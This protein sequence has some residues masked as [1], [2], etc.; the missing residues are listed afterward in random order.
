MALALLFRGGMKRISPLALLCAAPLVAGPLA[1]CT[2]EDDPYAGE[3][4][5]DADGKADTSAAAV[6]MDMESAVQTT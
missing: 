1:A 3:I 5:K 6:F 4:V 2:S